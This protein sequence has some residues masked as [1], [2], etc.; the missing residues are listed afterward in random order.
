MRC[1]A[2]RHK[3]GCSKSSERSDHNSPVNR[4]SPRLHTRHHSRRLP[5]GIPR[6]RVGDGVQ[7]YQSPYW[8][9]KLDNVYA[10]WQWWQRLCWGES[11]TMKF[12]YLAVAA[13]LVMKI[14]RKTPGRTAEI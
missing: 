8:R 13:V 11:R 12:R 1:P 7:Q 9:S 5:S 4:A 3:L 14:K 6:R 10:S 2:E